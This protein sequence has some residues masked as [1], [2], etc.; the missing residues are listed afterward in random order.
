MEKFNTQ[1]EAF[2]V[3]EFLVSEKMQIPAYRLAMFA[4]SCLHLVINS[5]HT[6]NYF[7]TYPKDLL[8]LAEYY[9]RNNGHFSMGIEHHIY[10]TIGYQILPFLKPHI[11][12]FD[13]LSQGEYGSQ[14]H[15]S[16]F[17]QLGQHLDSS[18]R[19]DL[20]PNFLMSD[21]QEGIGSSAKF[22]P[23]GEAGKRMGEKLAE[24]EELE[25]G[26]RYSIDVSNL[27]MNESYQALTDEE[28][29]RLLKSSLEY[30]QY[31]FI[32]Y[33]VGNS[34]FSQDF[35]NR[36]GDQLPPNRSRV[37]ELLQ[38]KYWN[39]A[40][41]YLYGTW[42][43]M[44]A[45]EEAQ[46]MF[47]YRMS[48]TAE[49][50]G[51]VEEYAYH[52]VCLAVLEEFR[53]LSPDAGN[54]TYLVEFWNK[55]R[56]P[57]FANAVTDALQHQGA[58]QAS[59]EIM[60]L[61]TGDERPNTNGLSAI[62]YRLELGKI[63]VSKEGVEYL[64][65][66]YNLQELNNPNFFAQRL[67]GQGDIGV[68]SQAGEIEGVFNLGDLTSEVSEIDAQVISLTSD[69]L[70][71]QD[72]EISDEEKRLRDEIVEQFRTHYFATFVQ[73]E[74]IRNETGVYINNLSLREQGALM[75]FVRTADENLVQQLFD[76]AKKY[77]EGAIR[78]L[79]V[80]NVN[81]VTV[82]IISQLEEHLDT[83]QMAVI[84]NAISSLSLTLTVLQ[85]VAGSSKDLRLKIL[86]EMDKVLLGTFSNAESDL[87]LE[88]LLSNL[89]R[90]DRRAAMYAMLGQSG[91]IP[92][93]DLGKADFEVL[94]SKD[95]STEDKRA[96]QILYRLNYSNDSEDTKLE[97]EGHL[98]D[99]FDT[100][101]RFYLVRYEGKV[102]GFA[103]VEQ[104]SKNTVHA[105]AFNTDKMFASIGSKVLMPLWR[106]EGQ[107]YFITA[108]YESAKV[109]LGESY[110]KLGFKEVS[111][112]ASEAGDSLMAIV[113]S[114]N[115]RLT[116][117]ET[118]T[119]PEMWQRY[120]TTNQN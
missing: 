54:V 75:Y 92:N 45:Y 24:A 82:D 4:R 31:I 102:R 120:S 49:T 60:K 51:Y 77:G 11:P 22:L 116:E 57:I 15:Y 79:M 61:V 84:F 46:A 93:E 96:M 42:Q 59:G 34:E 69:L 90:L 26:G 101:A 113:R 13:E 85:D 28:K 23:Y 88:A 105:S 112:L 67:T 106:H 19:K 30:L 8:V 63:G 109:E 114:P 18:E 95:L 97:L 73:D 62:L 70:F 39:E 21:H 32:F 16:R 47:N 66:L 48:T 36:F 6:E 40:H 58:L 35:M 108:E 71:V 87:D 104:I 50:G 94:Q 68:F 115:R 103:A 33:E 7:A 89:A 9:I 118:F 56:N 17:R 91:I 1:P 20:A 5:G 111:A 12:N 98:F 107:K 44:G 10:T 55:N 74:K 119:A 2:F 72:D 41:S 78:A 83:S 110:K 14:F 37:D 29:A 80:I 117:G 100:N 76:L 52:K 99:L 43:S 65:R 27:F 38:S 86:H 53:N 64:G 3:S 25:H 81:P